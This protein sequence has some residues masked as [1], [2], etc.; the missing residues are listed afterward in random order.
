MYKDY[1]RWTV[2]INRQHLHTWSIGIDYYH[3]L[4]FPDG[5]LSAKVC[6]IGLGLFNI[7]V[8]RWYAWT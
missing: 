7:T 5:V 8:T 6:I 2:H 4:D 3:L 1:G